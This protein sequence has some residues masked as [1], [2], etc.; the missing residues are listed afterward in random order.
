MFAPIH[1]LHNELECFPQQ[2]FLAYCIE[3]EP[4]A[5]V[6]KSFKTFYSCNFWVGKY[7][8]QSSPE[9]FLWVFTTN[10]NGFIIY[11]KMDMF[12]RKLVYFQLSATFTVLD[13]CSSLNKHTSLLQSLYIT[14][15][16]FW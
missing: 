8:R 2:A 14:N 6:G 12:H 16:Y 15:P 11:R 9:T 1:L 3:A 10:H 4:S 5:A 7:T 13:E